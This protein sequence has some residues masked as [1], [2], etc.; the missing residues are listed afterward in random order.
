MLIK[1]LLI[2]AACFKQSV[3]LAHT[4]EV[5]IRGMFTSLSR[6]DVEL[7]DFYPSDSLACCFRQGVVGNFMVCPVNVPKTWR[8]VSTAV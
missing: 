5:N 4:R 2:E 6:S 7:S 1:S 3:M 8:F